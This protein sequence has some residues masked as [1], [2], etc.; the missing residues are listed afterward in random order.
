LYLDV[1]LDY[2]NGGHD[3]NNFHFENTKKISSYMVNLIKRLIR[4]I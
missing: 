4:K 1:E 3:L 2:D